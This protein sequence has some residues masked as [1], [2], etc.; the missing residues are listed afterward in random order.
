MSKTPARGRPVPGSRPGRSPQAAALRRRRARRAR[1]AA[2]GAAAAA[3]AAVITVTVITAGGRGP[4]TAGGTTGTAG[5][6][7]PAAGSLAP[8]GTFTTAAGTTATI[9]SLR[10][11]PALVWLVT[12]W[13][14]GCQAGTAAMPGDLARLRARGIEVVELEDYADLGQP[15]PDIGSFGRQFAG[16][17]YH[18]PGWVFGTA[19]QALTQ[20][21]NPRGYLDIYYLVD[22]AGRIVY[23]GSAPAATMPQLLAHAARRT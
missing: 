1:W 9:S 14:P 2:A 20:A 21:Y 16:A 12:T 18:S 15:G 19:S 10:G 5:A 7:L 11:H 23:A 17:A 6:G 13:C 22:A 4:G 3:L 8:P